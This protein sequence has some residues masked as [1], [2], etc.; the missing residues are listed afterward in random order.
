M[1]FDSFTNLPSIAYEQSPSNQ[2]SINN[3]FM[4]KYMYTNIQKGTERVLDRLI[5]E[6]T[7]EDFDISRR[8]LMIIYP[9]PNKMAYNCLV[10]YCENESLIWN[11]LLIYV[12]EGRNGVNAD[13]NFFDTLEGLNEKGRKYQWKLV[14]TCPLKPFG[15]HD[16]KGFERLFIFKRELSKTKQNFTNFVTHLGGAGAGGGAGG[17]GP[18]S[19]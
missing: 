7:H 5:T 1:A 17:G 4:N 19:S 14:K 18:S 8:A 15:G 11:D 10:K 2:E 9:D 16:N 6:Q 13:Q 12:G 3:E